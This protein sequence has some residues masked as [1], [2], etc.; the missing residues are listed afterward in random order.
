MWMAVSS[1]NGREVVVKRQAMERQMN[2]STKSVS[3]KGVSTNGEANRRLAMGCLAGLAIIFSFASYLLQRSSTRTPESLVHPPSFITEIPNATNEE[4]ML[5]PGV[6]EKTASTW[7]NDLAPI[8]SLEDLHGVGPVRA[9]RLEPYV[10]NIAPHPTKNES[11]GRK[12]KSSPI[13][14]RATNE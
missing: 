12:P 2:C 10:A 11:K 6:G 1:T 8:E 13:K 3:A 14:V 9:E 4:W 7:R 5:L